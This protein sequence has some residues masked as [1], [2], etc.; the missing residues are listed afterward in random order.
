MSTQSFA[1]TRQFARSG[2][3]R[4][5]RRLRHAPDAAAAE[6]FHDVPGWRVAVVCLGPLLAVG[7]PQ[8]AASMDADL[9]R[10]GLIMLGVFIL[11]AWYWTTNAI[12]PFATAVLAMSL[13]AFLLGL[14]AGAGAGLDDRSSVSSWKDF[15]APASAPVIVLM[16][17]GFALGHAVHKL[18]IDR[19]LARTFLKPFARGPRSLVLGVLLVTGWMSMWISNTAT[20]AMMI[21]LVAPIL[22]QLPKGSKLRGAIVLAVPAGANIGG[23][24]TPIGT[25]P[26]AIAFGAIKAAE[27][28]ISFLGWM[29]FALPYA[30][31]ML[32]V[33]W[34]FLTRGLS[35]TDTVELDFGSAKSKPSARRAVVYASFI[36]AAGLWITS[37]WTGVPI[38]A[39]ALVPIVL[40]TA[41]G[42]LGRHDINSLDWDILLLIAGG[43]ALGRGMELTGLA[44]WMIG[45][46]PVTGLHPGVLLAFFC[47]GTLVLSTFMSN[48]AVANLA[49]PIALGVALTAE[50]LGATGAGVAV[51]LGASLSMG[52]PVSTPPNAIAYAS[53]AVKTTDFVRIGAFI[54]VIGVPLAVVIAGLI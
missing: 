25:P 21:T 49:M 34:V 24:G 23:I 45:A 13:M 33:C 18:G 48:T 4:L 41:L 46:I 9:G 22:A 20:A 19:Q 31:V 26:N 40:L 36:I 11:T 39:A 6:I 3:G 16:L 8:I 15:I 1:K 2:A 14:P 5:L 28:P 43:L 30:M 51:A 44:D 38:S 10:D 17:G 52:L 53:G 54:A 29:V 7:I 12:P 37:P 47:A 35:S 27:L 32:T 50:E 42:V